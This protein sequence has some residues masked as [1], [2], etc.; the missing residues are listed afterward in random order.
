[1]VDAGHLGL[2]AAYAAA[3]LAAGYLLV[4]VGLR[5]GRAAPLSAH[6][7]AERGRLR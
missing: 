3:T 1:M 7:D 4:R 5:I 2:A 6:E